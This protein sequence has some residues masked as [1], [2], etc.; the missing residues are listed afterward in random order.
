MPINNYKIKIPWEILILLLILVSNALFLHYNTFRCFNFF[1][2]G[3]F[4]DASWRVFRGQKPY[5]DFIYTTGLVR[6]YMNAF[7]FSFLGLVNWRS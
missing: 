2:M 5:V 1:D 6:L 7:S 4:L 3:G